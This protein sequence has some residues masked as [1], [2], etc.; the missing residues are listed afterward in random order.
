MGEP[1]NPIAGYPSRILPYAGHGTFVAGVLRTMAPKAEVWVD[2]TFPARGAVYESDLVKQLSDAA[3][4]GAGI[5]SLSFGTYSREDNPLLGFEV[6]KEWLQNYPD[7]VLVAAAGNDAI[8]SP[9]WPAAYPW[10]VSVGALGADRRSRASFSNYGTTVD[11]FVPGEGL[12][13]AFVRGDYLCTEP[14]NEGTWR[15]FDGMAR[16]SGTSFAV[17][18]VAGLIAARMSRTAENGRAAAD[19]LLRVAQTQAI[20]GVGPV[21]F[22]SEPEGRTG[23]DPE[24]VASHEAAPGDQTPVGAHPSKARSDRQPRAPTPP[25]HV[26]TPDRLPPAGDALVWREAELEHLLSILRRAGRRG[27]KRP[28]IVVVAGEP[29]M[30]KTFLAVHGAHRLRD[31]FPD[32]TLFIALGGASRPDTVRALRTTSQDLE[33]EQR[34]EAEWADAAAFLEQL[35]SR[36]RTAFSGRRI[37]V[38]V[39]DAQKLEMLNRSSRQNP[40]SALVVTSPSP[41]RL[42]NAELLSL[43]PLQNDEVAGRL[44][45]VLET[46]GVELS[47]ELLARVMAVT[48]GNPL[49]VSLTEAILREAPPQRVM[50]SL[51][52]EQR[53][54]EE[55]SSLVADRD[56]PEEVRESY[57]S[58]FDFGDSTSLPPAWAAAGSRLRSGLR[59]CPPGCG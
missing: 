43:S 15:K 57:R 45:Q 30:G 54:I 56:I 16:W 41:L 1:E 32:G 28:P 27:R 51:E 48:E 2:N 59:R 24:S 3:K 39:D 35:A 52:A 38:L 8:R 13:N 9:F 31:H 44:K 18:L 40:S 20:P 21:L 23:A 10:V 26:P 50:L 5:L 14:P 47:D 53:A 49:A 17:P 33:P 19:S 12:V 7:I 4:R 11:V 46:R 25:P 34:N 22:A 6:L 37:L 29:G 42:P 36:Y 55:A 58:L